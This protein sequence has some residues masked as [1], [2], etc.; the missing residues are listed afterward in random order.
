M[1]IDE[2]NR[3]IK[4]DFDTFSKYKKAFTQISEAESLNMVNKTKYLDDLLGLK[5]EDNK[6]LDEIIFL[7]KNGITELEKIK[8]DQHLKTISEIIIPVTDIYYQKILKEQKKN[9]DDLKNMAKNRSIYSKS[10]SEKKLEKNYK[11]IQREKI[12]DNK[13]I[14]LQFVL[15]ELKY[16]TASL[17]KLTDLFFKIMDK[18]PEALLENF[19]EKYHISDFNYN[20]IVENFKEIKEK[21]K[22]KKKKADKEKSSV[23]TNDD[24][25][26]E[27][28]NSD[29][30]ITESKSKVINSSIKKSKN[31]KIKKSKIIQNSNNNIEE[32]EKKE[33]ENDD[34]EKKEKEN[35]DEEKKIED[36]I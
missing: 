13:Y 24:D 4:N 28:E 29:E 22:N 31:K 7:F 5:E 18:K 10:S 8:S 16:H 32:E 35:V 26:E 23:Y 14:F 2:A 12:K 3:L 6:S 20:K 27:E 15:S 36:Q 33:K 1:N 30:I 21:E 17:E 9:L 19:G 25:K 11:K 34:E